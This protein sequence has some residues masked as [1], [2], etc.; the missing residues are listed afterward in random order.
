MS[1]LLLFAG[2]TTSPQVVI[3]VTAD[4]VVQV[5]PS[6][7]TIYVRPVVGTVEV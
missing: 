4:V 5:R 7:G 1:L 3:E 2:A 6:V